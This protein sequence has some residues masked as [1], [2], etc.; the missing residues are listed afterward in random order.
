MQN[1]DREPQY[2]GTHK[3]ITRVQLGWTTLYFREGAYT[4]AVGTL[5]GTHEEPTREDITAARKMIP[6]SPRPPTMAHAPAEKRA[7][8]RKPDAEEKA[9]AKASPREKKPAAPAPAPA[10]KAPAKRSPARVPS[11]KKAPA[12]RAAPPK[13]TEKATTAPI[14]TMAALEK[15]L[16]TGGR[17]AKTEAIDSIAELEAA[18]ETSPPRRRKR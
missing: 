6:L 13:G 4:H 1:K 16:A 7:P 11:A 10:A 8:S 18:L 5:Y 3:G 14:E 17:G 2:M 9:R 12:R 15:S